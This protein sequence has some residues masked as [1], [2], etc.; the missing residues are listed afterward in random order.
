MNRTFRK[1]SAGPRLSAEE[2][3]RQGRCSTLAFL[4]LGREGALLFLNAH[5]D[6]LGGRPLDVAIASAEG[7]AAVERAI[8]A[9]KAP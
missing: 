5:D 3:Q 7:L 4:T 8:D 2:A 6:A 1:A 9:R